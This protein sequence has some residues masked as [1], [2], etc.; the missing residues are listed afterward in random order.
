MV[1]LSLEKRRAGRSLG[2]LIETIG[3]AVADPGHAHIWTDHYEPRQRTIVNLM[4]RRADEICL[5]LGLRMSIVEDGLQ[6]NITSLHRPTYVG[7][8]GQTYRRTD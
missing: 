8:D 2:T 1:T 5:E 3:R 7:S 4:K 6:L